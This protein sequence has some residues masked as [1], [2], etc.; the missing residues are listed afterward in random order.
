MLFLL[1]RASL[2]ERLQAA[3]IAYLDHAVEA[4]R[5]ELVRPLR[6]LRKR[7]KSNPFTL[8]NSSQ[9]AIREQ[10][11]RVELQ[12]EKQQ[13]MYMEEIYLERL[14]ISAQRCLPA[15]AAAA[16]LSAYADRLRID[17][18]S[19]PLTTLLARFEEVMT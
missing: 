19:A 13:Q 18:Q 6:A 12:T 16:N 14:P 3:E 17:A 2:G 5:S 1:F 4:W 8:S 15:T 11:L 10:L 9:Q 7:L